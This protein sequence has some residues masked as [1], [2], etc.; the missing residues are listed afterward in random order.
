MSKELS[1]NNTNS[2]TKTIARAAISGQYYCCLQVDL[3][4]SVDSF[5]QVPSEEIWNWASSNSLSE[6]ALIDVS[7]RDG[8]EITTIFYRLLAQATSPSTVLRRLEPLFRRRLSGN[9][10]RMSP[11]KARLRDKKPTEECDEAAAAAAAGV[12]AVG[13]TKLSRSRSLMRRVNKPK[14]KR[15]LETSSPRNDCIIS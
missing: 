13:G 2:H 1:L 9:G 6:S 12:G 3:D 8:T 11:H 15:S 7:A 4:N 14:V 5:R 10:L